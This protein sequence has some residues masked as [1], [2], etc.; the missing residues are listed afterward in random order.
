MSVWFYLPERHQPSPE[1]TG[2]HFYFCFRDQK[3]QRY[4]KNRPITSP[5]CHFY[6]PPLNLRRL[7]IK[8]SF[9][10][11]NMFSISH[12]SWDVYSENSPSFWCES[13]VCWGIVQHLLVQQQ[14]QAQGLFHLWR[15]DT[16]T[17]RPAEG[18][19]NQKNHKTPEMNCRSTVKHSTPF[20]QMLS[21]VPSLE[22]VYGFKEIKAEF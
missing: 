14:H 3:V 7:K 10:G 12:L 4:Q 1:S 6:S 18:D 15:S 2:L 13:D 9:V 11:M 16:T 22:P 20:M 19:M 5:N 8:L 17:C 21:L